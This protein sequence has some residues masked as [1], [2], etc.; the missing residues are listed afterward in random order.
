[1]LCTLKLNLSL[2]FLMMIDNYWWFFLYLAKA[3]DTRNKLLYVNVE[4]TSLIGF[5]TEAKKFTNQFFYR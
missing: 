2:N 3:L 5:K 4:A 1:M